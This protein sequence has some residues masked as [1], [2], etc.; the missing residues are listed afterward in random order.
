[1]KDIATITRVTPEVRHRS[2]MQYINR[3]NN[4]PEAKQLLA[5]WG[6]KLV[7][8]LELTARMLDEEKVYFANQNKTF[9]VGPN[10]DFG[11]YITNNPAL[12]VV[13]LSKWLLIHVK[14][15]HKAATAF[16]ECMQRNSKPM[17]INVAAPKIIKLDDDKTETY[18]DMLRNAISADI[19]IVVIICPTAR[20]DRYAVIKKICNGEV[21]IPS[22]VRNVF[23]LIYSCKNFFRKSN[24]KINFFE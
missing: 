17:G 23:H 20:D 2:L 7:E 8:P 3:V 19:Q 16:L 4:Q 11:K 18:A 22:Q 21:P 13:H 6:L 14:T 12:S 5:D 24:R 15:E 10:A 1:M 9:G